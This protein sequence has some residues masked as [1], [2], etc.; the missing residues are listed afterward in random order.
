M[1]SVYINLILFLIIISFFVLSLSKKKNIFLDIKDKQHKNFATQAKNHS[2]GGVLLLI[3]FIYF[4]FFIDKLQ[5][6]H[7]L[8]FGLIFLVG[9]FSDFKL[10]DDPKKRFLIQV[11]LLLTFIYL[12][13]LEIPLTKV[14]FIDHYLKN[15]Y[16][17]KFFTIFCLMVFINGSN[18]IDGLNTLLIGYNFLICLFL[19]LFFEPALPDILIIK[20]LLLFLLI[21]LIFNFFGQ[22]ILGDSGS[23]LISFFMGIYLINFSNSTNSVS[24]FFI[25]LLLWYP[26]FEL[27][28]SMIRRLFFKQ[29]M[30][31]PDTN[32]LH[33]ILFKFFTKNIKNQ[34]VNHLTVSMFI[35]GYT[36]LMLFVLIN[37]N[38]YLKVSHILFAILTNLIV[39]M[40]CYFLIKKS[41]KGQ[42]G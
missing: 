25:I 19:V 11:I 1:L 15:I 41:L 17:N 42:Y 20:C 26:C 33:Q 24:P 12:V 37:M 7:I 2:I 13:D 36:F 4:H 3:F 39:Y 32:H 40:L 28:F 27:L 38:T 34:N 23:Y 6:I 16:F 30:Y 29:K 18:F 9:F 35:N 14:A 5:N 31:E 21:I 8:F 22:I 10:L